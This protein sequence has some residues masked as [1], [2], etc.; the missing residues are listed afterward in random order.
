[1]NILF[2]AITCNEPESHPLFETSNQLTSSGY[3]RIF[4]CYS[5]GTIR[6]T[7]IIKQDILKLEKRIATGRKKK[8]LIPLLFGKKAAA[9]NKKKRK[10]E[11]SIEEMEVSS[12]S[13][14]KTQHIVID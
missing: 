11:T 10:Q 14:D 4:T 3:E 1:V 2:E 9:Q 13:H 12:S 6:I 7:N 5:K 8:D